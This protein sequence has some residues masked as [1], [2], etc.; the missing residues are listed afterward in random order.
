M[1]IYHNNSCSKSRIALAELTKSGEEFE[2][3]NYLEQTPSVSELTEIVDKLGIKPYDLI[4]VTEKLYKEKYKDQN[5]SDEEWIEVMHKNPILIQRPI[6]VAGDIAVIA[7]S[8][9]ELD[10]VI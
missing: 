7:R 4:R 6:I 8:E 5:L 9:E 1:K 3:I 2:V 10:K